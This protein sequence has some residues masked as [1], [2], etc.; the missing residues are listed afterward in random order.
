MQLLDVLKLLSESNTKPSG[1]YGL[2]WDLSQWRRKYYYQRS[3]LQATRRELDKLRKGPS[4][5]L[6]KHWLVGVG[7]SD[8]KTSLRSVAA[9]CKDFAIDS[10]SPICKSSVAEVR[11]AC[12]SSSMGSTG[13]T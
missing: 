2:Q 3:L 6:S 10:C 12:G 13:R 9:F 1:R 11:N 7:L 5:F 8:P 4:L